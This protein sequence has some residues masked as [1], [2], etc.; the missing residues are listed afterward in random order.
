MSSQTLGECCASG[1]LHEGTPNGKVIKLHDLDVYVTG[2]ESNKAKTVVYLTDIFGY[3]LNNA[4]LL[5]DEIASNGFWVVVPDFFHHDSLD[6]DLILKIAP[7]TSLPE[8]SVVQKGLDTA[9]TMASLGPWLVRHREAV[10]LPIIES[11]MKALR[12]DSAIKKIGAVGYCFGGRYS[13]LMAHGLADAAVAC[14]PSFLAVPADLEGITKPSCETDLSLLSCL[15]QDDM[16]VESDQGK[17]QVFFNENLKPKGIE[18]E[19]ETYKDQVHGWAVRGD[20]NVESEK[21]AKERAEKQV[22]EWF[23]KHLA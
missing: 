22:V 1:H 19:F 15:L 17:M 9:S 23:K 2:D 7:R 5:A 4:R 3:D 21:A 13:V 11:F 8:R 16:F 18:T 6:G 20:I 10:I 14:H 12:T